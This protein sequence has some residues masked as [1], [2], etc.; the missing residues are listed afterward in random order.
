MGSSC[1]FCDGNEKEGY[2]GNNNERKEESMANGNPPTLIQRNALHIEER[3]INSQH[4]ESSMRESKDSVIILRSQKSP[5]DN[6]NRVE[7]SENN[8]IVSSMKSERKRRAV[9]DHFDSFKVTENILTLD[10]KM[11]ESEAKN[12]EN[13]VQNL[14]IFNRL[15]QEGM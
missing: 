10:K 2:L 8:K 9:L 11:E 4:F 3:R 6:M 12:I 1:S 5:R 15:S 7:S 13:K 14:Y